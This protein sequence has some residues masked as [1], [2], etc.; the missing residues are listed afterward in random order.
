MKGA[1]ECAANSSSPNI[2][3]SEAD[4]PCEDGFASIKRHDELEDASRSPSTR[5]SDSLSDRITS[6]RDAGDAMGE[7]DD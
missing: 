6:K 5:F 4:A 1:E 2:C 3:S 7:C